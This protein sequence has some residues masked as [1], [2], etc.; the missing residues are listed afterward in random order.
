MPTVASST[1]P[2]DASL[3]PE[4]SSSSG[5]LA[6]RAAS[7]TVATM[8]SRVLGVVREVVLASLFGAGNDMDA[9]RIAFRVPNMLRD[10]FAEGVMSAAFVPTFTRRL[11][12]DGRSSALRLGLSATNAL[13]VI[14][15]TEG[16]EAHAMAL[17]ASGYLTKPLEVA[18]VARIV[19]RLVSR[20]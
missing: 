20:R 18:E 12:L 5:A 13:L 8:A 9:F 1:T 15:G 4:G 2:F 19:Q 10:L 6:R 17:G 11:T 14:T 16:A 7:G 3:G